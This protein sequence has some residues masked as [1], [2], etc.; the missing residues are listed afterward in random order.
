[1]F[2]VRVNF[3]SIGKVAEVTESA[4]AFVLKSILSAINSCVKKEIGIK[5]NLRLGLLKINSSGTLN[6]T[7]FG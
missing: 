7:S 5:L 2:P 1:M 3:H 4:A 6:F